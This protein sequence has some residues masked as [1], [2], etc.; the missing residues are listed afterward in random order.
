MN[1]CLHGG[2]KLASR[3]YLGPLEFHLQ[4]RRRTRCL[5]RVGNSTASSLS[6]TSRTL[7]FR[8]RPDTQVALFFASF[9]A[10]DQSRA[11]YI[12]SVRGSYKETFSICPQSFFPS[13]RP[14]LLCVAELF[15]VHRPFYFAA[16]EEE[17]AKRRFVLE[18]KGLT[19]QENL[20]QGTHRAM[21]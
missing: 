8:F 16:L 3:R 21:S 7:V 15:C 11:L 6:K 4:R 18:I 20:N 12:C 1:V 17:R 9:P 2:T 19:R 14:A 5:S 13:P 10:F